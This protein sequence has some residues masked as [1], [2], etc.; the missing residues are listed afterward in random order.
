MNTITLS[1][2]KLGHNLSP[3]KLEHHL[4]H[5]DNNSKNQST[6]NETVVQLEVWKTAFVTNDWLVQVKYC[7][8]CLDCESILFNSKL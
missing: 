4:Q 5:A 6:P 1:Y 8:S 3:I 2:M 7:E